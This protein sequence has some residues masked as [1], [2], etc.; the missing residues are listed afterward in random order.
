MI[1]CWFP[2]VN[3]FFGEFKLCLFVGGN[4]LRIYCVFILNH[5][6]DDLRIVTEIAF[7]S[8][9]CTEETLI[10]L[11]LVFLSCILPVKSH[12]SHTVHSIFSG[13]YWHCGEYPTPNRVSNLFRGSCRTSCKKQIQPEGL[14]T[15]IQKTSSFPPSQFVILC[16]LNDNSTL[17]RTDEDKTI[18][19]NLQ[20]HDP[21]DKSPDWEGDRP[22]IFF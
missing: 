22:C 5:V 7:A 11:N 19:M 18:K 17:W 4:K 10:S 12:L 1:V 13:R 6:K 3:I 8:F 2:F 9:P 21:C 15:Q 16:C 20:N 14:I